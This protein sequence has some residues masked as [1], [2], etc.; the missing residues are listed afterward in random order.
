MSSARALCR[1]VNIAGKRGVG[2]TRRSPTRRL[3]SSRKFP[4]YTLSLSAGWSRG[5]T[6]NTH[7]IVLL[8]AR[9]AFINMAR[10]LKWAYYT[11]MDYSMTWYE[12]CPQCVE[13]KAPNVGRLHG[14]GSQV[15]R[16]L[17]HYN[18]LQ[19][20]VSN[21]CS[22]YPHLLIKAVRDLPASRPPLKGRGRAGPKV[23]RR[24]GLHS[25]KEARGV[26]LRVLVGGPLPRDS[27]RGDVVHALRRNVAPLVTIGQLRGR[28][29]P[30]VYF[31]HRRASQ[32]TRAGIEA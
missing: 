7:A 24:F 27:H 4:L 12:L 25:T 1:C 29:L 18:R 15:C 26:Q 30:S 28:P 10:A 16:P 22:P 21:R 2:E 6:Y 32:P 20:L 13:P 9:R 19:Q 11:M 23:G 5:S 14:G 17:L 31:T 3:L 8:G